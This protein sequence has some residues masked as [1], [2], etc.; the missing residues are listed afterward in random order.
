MESLTSLWISEIFSLSCVALVR[1]TM[2]SFFDGSIHMK[3]PE[4]ELYPKAAGE[5]T[6]PVQDESVGFDHGPSAPE[7]L[8][9]VSGLKKR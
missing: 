4:A 9:I 6:L 2:N 7:N 8:A 1:N 5:N 3:D